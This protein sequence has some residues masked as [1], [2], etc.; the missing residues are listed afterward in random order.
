MHPVIRRFAQLSVVLALGVPVGWS[1]GGDSSNSD[2]TDPSG[3][4][5][6]GSAGTSGTGGSGATGASGGSGGTAGASVGGGAGATAGTG[7]GAGE[8]GYAG[9]A[10][11]SPTC[12]GSTGLQALAHWSNGPSF[13]VAESGGYLYV[14]QGG[15]IRVY[16]VSSAAK[17]SAL[18]DVNTSWKNYVSR[19]DLEYFINGITI[20][21][22]YL[23][24]ASLSS[25]AIVSIADPL[26]PTIVATIPSPYPSQVTLTSVRVKGNYAY[27]SLSSPNPTSSTIPG[28]VLAIDISDKSHPV[29]RNTPHQLQD[30]DSPRIDIAG[31]YLYVALHLASGGVN[32]RLDIYSISDPAA[33]TW[34][35]KYTSPLAHSYSSV[36]VRGNYAF[37]AE[38]HW[39]LRVIDVST[40]SAPF[41]AGSMVGAQENDFNASDVKLLGNYAYVSTRYEGYRKIDISGAPALSLVGT[42]DLVGGYDEGV[43]ANGN[44]VFVSSSSTGFLIFDQNTSPWSPVANVKTPGGADSLAVGN[45]RVYVGAHNDGVWM[46]NASNLSNFHEEAFVL[47]HGRNF[48]IDLQGNFVFTAGA[49]RGLSVLS[50]A[51]DPSNSQMIIEN[52]GEPLDAVLTDGDYA[53]TSDGYPATGPNAA[54]PGGVVDISHVT[55]DSSVSYVTR[56]ELFRYSNFIKWTA[57]RLVVTTSLGDNKGLRVFDVSN[58]A[59]PQVVGSYGTGVAYRPGAVVGDVAIALHDNSI[60]AL[61]LYPNA[62]PTK[63][64]ELTYPGVF[65]GAGAAVIG[66]LVYAIGGGKIKVID[67]S[68]PTQIKDLGTVDLHSGSLNAIRSNSG[69][70]YVGGSDSGVYVMC[71]WK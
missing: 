42:S 26:H 67:V 12:S 64:S 29:I 22:G 36:A 52:Y 28:G 37:V 3:E 9:A 24:A 8:G 5:T 20:D 69:M 14:A 65:A 71:P 46:L 41:E 70:L 43:F 18:T 21:S 49:W 63:L 50:H 44:Y 62:D 47:T 57:D 68:D 55:A 61:R 7:A 35:G 6:A 40:P 10:G 53:Y 23:Y 27:V 59:S 1:C 54:Q 32:G 56:V 13:D 33:P 38:Y 66:N 58:K 31:D 51:S 25:F 17:V 15:E 16:D 39:G 2:Q 4:P 19:V 34:V 30:G 60:E 48:G 11:A 45:S